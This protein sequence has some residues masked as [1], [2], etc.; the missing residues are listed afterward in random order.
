MAD[1]RTAAGFRA[2]WKELV[3]PVVCDRSKGSRLWDIDGNEFIDLVNGFG[4][5]AFGHSP[6]F[7]V[8][9]ITRQMERGFAIGPQ[10]DLAGPIAE[11]FARF[12]GH[13]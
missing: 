6:D 12:V 4:Q 10:S 11:R 8:D 3:F 1:P 2:E 13:Q 9:A 5:T 7:V